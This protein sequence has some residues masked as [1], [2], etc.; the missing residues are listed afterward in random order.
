M[1]TPTLYTL[2]GLQK[3]INSGTSVMLGAAR[4]PARPLGYWSL[5]ERLRCTWAV[6]TGRADAV[7]WPGGQ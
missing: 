2:D 6:F 1:N 7:I 3:T 5:P 4:Y